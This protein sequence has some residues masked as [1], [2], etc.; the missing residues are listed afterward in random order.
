[1]QVFN[2]AVSF[3]IIVRRV[4]QQFLVQYDWSIEYLYNEQEIS[5]ENIP[6]NKRHL[7]HHNHR[8]QEM[9]GFRQM[10][11][12]E[13][14]QMSDLEN[15]QRDISEINAGIPSP[16]GRT[17][18]LGGG[19]G[20]TASKI[21]KVVE[22]VVGEKRIE[23]L[24]AYLTEKRRVL[25]RAV[26]GEMLCTFLFLFTVMATAVN[27]V[28]VGSDSSAIVGGVSTAFVSVA[29]IYSFA[30]VSGAHFNPAVTF[31]T[32][33]TGKTSILKGL[34]YILAQLFAAIMATV[35][36]FAIFPNVDAV[37]STVV[38]TKYDDANLWGALATEFILSFILIYVIFAVAFDT[39]DTK[40]EVKLSLPTNEDEKESQ[41]NTVNTQI[42][43]KIAKNL[44]IYTTNGNSK[45]GFAPIAIGFTLGFLCFVGGSTSGGAFNPA[46][47]FG[48][49]LIGWNWNHHWLYWVGDFMGAALAGFTQMFFSHR[50]VQIS[51][52]NIPTPQ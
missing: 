26:L 36:L 47:V 17:G 2:S 33:V 31:A 8:R 44:T 45:A 16:S 20:P 19:S 24:R 10:D 14:L 41:Q 5:V 52:D 25:I 51:Y 35:F 29:L 4:N 18:S 30:D 15:Q 43:R 46:R 34:L 7:S 22:K 37:M 38:V 9:S 23:D 50:A 3:E 48:P 49:A 11:D 21:G 1:M 39:V 28:R 40:N 6:K 13:Y 27:G 12:S 42:D 32:I